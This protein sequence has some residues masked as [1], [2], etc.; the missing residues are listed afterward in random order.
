MFSLSRVMRAR[1]AATTAVVVTAL[2]VAVPLLDRG[3]DPDA[4]AF[5]ER[6]APIGYVEHNHS[7]CLQHGQAVWTPV[8][9]AELPAQRFV[10][11][12]DSP[13]RTVVHVPGPAVS[14]HQSRAP[15]F[16]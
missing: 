12:E 16:V 2:S 15:P 7:V 13:C 1:V 4:L 10:R 6:G 5:S 14:S 8:A 11:Q 9:A 3:Q